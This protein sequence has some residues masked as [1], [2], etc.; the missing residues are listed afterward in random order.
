MIICPSCCQFLIEERIQIEL[1]GKSYYS[2][3]MG[4]DDE[5]IPLVGTLFSISL[6]FDNCQL[7]LLLPFL[8]FALLLSCNNH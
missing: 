5:N 6:I 7:I 4:L 2:Q 3:H 8:F 1:V